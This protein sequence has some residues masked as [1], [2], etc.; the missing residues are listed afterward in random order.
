MQ[1]QLFS[2]EFVLRNIDF[3]ETA[4]YFLLTTKDYNMIQRKQTLWLLLAALVNAG[5]FYFAMYRVHVLKDGIDTLEEMHVYNRYPI[6]LM[7]LVITALPLVAIF[8]FRNRKRQRAVT[9]FAIVTNIGFIATV[10]MRVGNFTHKNPNA[11]N[12]TYW[13]GSI[14]PV[15]AIVLLVMAVIGINKDEKLVKSQ[16][17][18]R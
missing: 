10:I 5:L 8:L 7:A 14:L 3:L 11:S 18:L 16:D 17:R 12:G 9:I 6:L 1:R 2:F 15:I 13:I 4:L